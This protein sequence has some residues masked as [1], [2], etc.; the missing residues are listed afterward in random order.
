MACSWLCL[1]TY[2]LCPT[3]LL[4]F[5]IPMCE[6]WDMEIS[7]LPIPLW[8][9]ICR[10]QVAYIGYNRNLKHQQLCLMDVHERPLGKANLG[11]QCSCNASWLSGCWLIRRG[12]YTRRNVISTTETSRIPSTTYFHVE[13]AYCN[14]HI[15]LHPMSN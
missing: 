6:I 13:L 7:G 8:H 11:S 12:D 9:C 4:P 5:S 10:L 15:H 1:A 3:P 14:C 2:H